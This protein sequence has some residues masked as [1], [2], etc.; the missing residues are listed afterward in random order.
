MSAEIVWRAYSFQY[1][2]TVSHIEHAHLHI[3]TETDTTNP[4][5]KVSLFH[6]RVLIAVDPNSIL[7]SI[8]MQFTN[9]WTHPTPNKRSDQTIYLT[10][11]L[12]EGD[13]FK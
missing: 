7:Y 10:L 6:S 11:G 4:P 3:T 1:V 9:A 12:K 2:F 5:Y 13:T 8:Q